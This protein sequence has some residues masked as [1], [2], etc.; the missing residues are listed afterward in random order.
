VD[1]ETFGKYGGMNRVINYDVCIGC[2]TCEEV[3]SFLHEG[4]GYIKL[5]DIGGGLNKPIS[6][7]HCAKAPC[8]TACP[9]GAMHKDRDGAVLVD[10]SK[11]IGCSACL[12]ACPFGIPEIIP[13]G[14]ATKCDLCNPLRA[15]GLTPGCVSMCP[16]R[17]IAWGTTAEVARELRVRALR[18][19]VYK[20]TV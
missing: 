4:S 14:F 19:L 13:P 18:K 5:Y 20:P 8:I 2:Y 10:I 3:C 11:C 15:E 6:C 12:A 7:F 1:L 17:A 9:T 16:T